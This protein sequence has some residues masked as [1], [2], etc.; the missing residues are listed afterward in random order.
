MMQWYLTAQ[1]KYQA[2]NDCRSDVTNIK[3]SKCSGTRGD[4]SEL[5]EYTLHRNYQPS[6]NPCSA[7]DPF[8]ISS[9]LSDPQS[10][11]TVKTFIGYEPE[12]EELSVTP[13]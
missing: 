11:D 12:A 3:L 4:S 13:S 9:S 5:D 8:M 2:R 6:F 10:V 1:S 7:T